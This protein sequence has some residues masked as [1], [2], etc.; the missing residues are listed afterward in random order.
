MVQMYP[1]VCIAAVVNRHI[2]IGQN[3]DAL[4][5]LSS[6]AGVVF[7]DP[8]NWLKSVV[9]VSGI[10]DQEV[11]AVMLDSEKIGYGKPDFRL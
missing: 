6:F 2:A 8:T 11:L 4:E 1:E 7:I 10:S 3:A 9:L 5:I